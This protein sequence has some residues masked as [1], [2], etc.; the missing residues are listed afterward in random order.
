[1][2]YCGYCKGVILTNE[3]RWKVEDV[4]LHTTLRPGATGDDPHDTCYWAFKREARAKHI[5][6]PATVFQLRFRQR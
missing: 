5:L 6:W 4:S 2:A 1:M 3:D